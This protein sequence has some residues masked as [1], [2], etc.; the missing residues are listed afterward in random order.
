MNYNSVD[1]DFDFGL[2]NEG[3]HDDIVFYDSFKIVHP[4]D[5]ILKNLNPF[6]ASGFTSRTMVEVSFMLKG[7][8]LRTQFKTRLWFH[9]YNL[10]LNKKLPISLLLS[11]YYGL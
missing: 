5:G 3:F 8:V 9:Q 6:A 11:R 1:I 10:I 7:K 4:D 2:V